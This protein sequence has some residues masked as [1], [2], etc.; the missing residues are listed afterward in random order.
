[1]ARTPNLF[2]YQGIE[3]RPENFASR[4]YSHLVFTRYNSVAAALFLLRTIWSVG[5]IVARAST[6]DVADCLA[7][8]R[9][10]AFNPTCG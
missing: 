4:A 7:Q 3:K 9:L 5:I 1:L 10:R 6:R 2:R 8:D